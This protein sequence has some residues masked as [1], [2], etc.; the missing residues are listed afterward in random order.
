MKENMEELKI[1]E[2]DI[3]K[4][5]QKLKPNKSP[6]P[7]GIHPKFIK[8]IGETIAEPLAIIFNKS[9]DLKCIPNQ[10]KQA[11]ICAIFKKRK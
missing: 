9:L 1:E 3:I 11:M 8:N 7:D 10:W 6:G 4:E 2:K 5:T